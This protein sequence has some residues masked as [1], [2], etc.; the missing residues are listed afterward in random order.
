MCALQT[1]LGVVSAVTPSEGPLQV[2][3]PSLHCRQAARLGSARVWEGSGFSWVAAAAAV[4]AS[5]ALSFGSFARLVVC[6]FVRVFVC[7]CVCLFAC[8]CR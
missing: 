2:R 4:F 7:A 8:L 3:R 6:L 5:G 1:N